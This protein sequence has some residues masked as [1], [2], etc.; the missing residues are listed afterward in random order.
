MGHAARSCAKHDEGNI[1]SSRQIQNPQDNENIG[2]LH[3]GG[4]NVK[5]RSCFLLV[6]DPSTHLLS[7][8]LTR[9]V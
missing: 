1:F 8:V 9:G 4:D 3:N 6:F 5:Q 2:P 7:G